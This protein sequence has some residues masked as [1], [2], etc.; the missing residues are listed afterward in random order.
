MLNSW[1]ETISFEETYFL[2]TFYDLY[3]F[4]QTNTVISSRGGLEVEH[5]DCKVFSLLRWIES[6]FGH[7]QGKNY[8]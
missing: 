1:I 6:C 5:V 8:E 7:A 4:T 3:F 2:T